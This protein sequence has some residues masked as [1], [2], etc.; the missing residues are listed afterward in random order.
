MM[1]H[2]EPLI[3]ESSP[4][5]QTN[6]DKPTQI[7]VGVQSK[8]TLK[9]EYAFLRRFPTDVAAGAVRKTVGH[10]QYSAM[11]MGN[12]YVCVHKKISNRLAMW[13]HLASLK[14]SWVVAN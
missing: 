4:N 12:M 6:H 3:F 10:E 7:D 11:A 1:N 2:L 13:P 5:V 8:V 9:K 14:P